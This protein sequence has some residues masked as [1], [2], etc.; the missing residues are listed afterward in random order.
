MV[1]PKVSFPMR[2][3]TF[4]NT[5]T[6]LTFILNSLIKVRIIQQQNETKSTK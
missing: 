1:F 5:L 6:T 4:P 2:F 3:Y